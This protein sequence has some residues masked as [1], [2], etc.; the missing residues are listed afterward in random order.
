MKGVRVLRRLR[1]DPL[2]WIGGVLV[3]AVVLMAL[4]ADA[5]S[6]HAPDR[7]VTLAG[8]RAP[9]APNDRYP[10]GTD[11]N[12]YD[13]ASRL[14]HGARTSLLTGACAVLL[15][16]AIGVP[17]GAAAGWKGGF[18]DGLLMRATDVMLAFPSVLLALVIAAALG[19]GSVWTLVLAVGIVQVPIFMR[20]VRAS[21]MQLRHEDWVT[22]CRAT[23]LSSSRT[24]ARHVLPNCLAPI[25][26]LSTLGVGSAIL[27]AAGL[28]WLGLGPPATEPE[29][30]R[31]LEEGA[32]FM[33]ERQQWI[34]VPPG[35]AI[36]ATVLGFNLLGDAL[37]AA[38][39]PR[40]AR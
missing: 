23:G 30:G 19:R 17:L 8:E 15:A 1:R 28:S 36:A 9:V 13:V 6:P 35:V 4:L 12:G 27:S 16:L 24:L 5:V 22:A 32:K 40:L 33:R 25:L 10:L 37:R 26:V 18:L 11:E 20:Q 3:G 21:V 34:I 38:L 29:W 31:M 2:F 7:R 14:L 39:D